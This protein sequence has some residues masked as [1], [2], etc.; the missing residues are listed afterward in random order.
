MCYFSYLSQIIGLPWQWNNKEQMDIDD[1]QVCRIYFT[2]FKWFVYI[3]LHKAIMY[4]ILAP[5]QK[6]I[7]AYKKKIHRNY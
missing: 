6:N 2:T 1:S 4:N 7:T 5:P 3:K